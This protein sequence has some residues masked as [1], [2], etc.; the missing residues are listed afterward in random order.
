MFKI[1]SKDKKTRARVGIIQTPHGKIETPS[2]VVVATKAKIKTLRPADIK[3]TKTQIVISNTYHL[4]EKALKKGAKN[5]VHQTLAVKIPAMTDSGGFQV[6][7]L[8]FGMEN[9]V[10]KKKRLKK[11]KEKILG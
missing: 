10:G 6:F 8:G 4:W 3:K 7:S 9:K 11:S 2:Y 5:V 1:I